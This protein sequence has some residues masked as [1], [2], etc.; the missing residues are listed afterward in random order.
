MP[1]NTSL[2]DAILTDLTTNSPSTSEEIAVRINSSTKSVATAC[3]WLR[4]NGKVSDG[5]TYT[6]TSPGILTADRPAG[7]VKW[8]L[9]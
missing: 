7:S 9:I 4:G 2:A 5:T 1:H 3:A 8:S 6:Q